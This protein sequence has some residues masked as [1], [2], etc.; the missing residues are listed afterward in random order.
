MDSPSRIHVSDGLGQAERA[1]AA[2]QDGYFN[3]NEMTLPALLSLAVK[4]AGLVAFVDPQRAG[5]S[6]EQ[7]FAAD[8]TVVISNMLN[9]ELRAPAERFNAWLDA[10]NQP[11][12]KKDELPTF[13]LVN[14]LDGWH[15]L[16]ARSAAN[17][18][19]AALRGLIASVM[20]RLKP[21]L[22]PL[23]RIAAEGEG[24]MTR[25]AAQA[26]RR[27]SAA[28]LA[29]P[30]AAQRPADREAERRMLR[31]S[32]YSLLKGVELVQRE[33]ARRLE[34]SLKSQRHDGA[35]ALLI[36]FCQL[37]LRLKFK[38]NRFT[39]QHLDFYHRRVLGLRPQ[40][41][42]PD[43]AYLVLSAAGA[44]IEVEIK[45]G[46][47][48]VAGRDAEQRDI[49]YT[50]DEDLSVADAR[51]AALRMLYFRR[52]PRISPENM[53]Y[54]DGPDEYT[55]GRAFPTGCWTDRVPLAPGAPPVIGHERLPHALFGT[56]KPNTV[57][58]YRAPARLGFAVASPM[59]LLA[60]GRRT[61]ELTLKFDD[62]L[63]WLEQ[64][65]RTIAAAMHGGD[66]G[67][68]EE[69]DAFFKIFRDI[70][71]VE[72]T[73]ETGWTTVEEYLPSYAGVDSARPANALALRMVL[74]PEFP[75][76]TA[77]DRAVH[78]EQYGTVSPV[79][80]FTLRD[81][82]Y[83]YPYALLKSL[84]VRE[85]RIAV[86]AEGCRK[87]IL[88]NGIG[89]LSPL[90]AFAPFGPQPAIGS[91]LVVG[92][93]E[94][95]RK[96]L[97]AF[98]VEIEW[99]GL[100]L[101]PGGFRAYYA[102]YDDPPATEE[103]RANLSTLVDGRWLPELE[104][105][106]ELQLYEVEADDSRRAAIAPRR[107]LSCKRVLHAYKPLRDSSV[108]DAFGPE[109]R[110][111][112]FRF[113]LS[114]PDFAFG[115][116]AYPNVLA[117][118]LAHNTRQKVE[119]RRRA[120]PNPPYTPMINAIGVSYRAESAFEVLRGGETVDEKL[121][122]LHPFGVE[123]LPSSTYG[124]IG[125]V[126]AY[127]EAG[128]LYIGV[129]ARKPSGRLTLMFH[130]H[131]DSEPLQPEVERSIRWHYL[132]DNQWKPLRADRIL[133]DS[134]EAFLVSGVVTLELPPDID[135]D[136]TVMPNG[137]HWLRISADG[138]DRAL[139]AFCSVHGVYINA[140]RVTW[141]Q[142]EEGGERADLTIPPGTITGPQDAIPGLASVTQVASSFGGRAAEGDA[143]LR[144]RA[145]E[146]LRHKQ[147]ALLPADYEQLVLEHFPE[148]YKVK[149]FPNLRQRIEHDRRI[150]PGG[151][152]IVPIAHARNEVEA[153][154]MPVLSGHLLGRIHRY[155][156][157][158]A[159]PD[160][161]IEVRNPWFERIQVR[162]TVELR[163]PYHTGRDLRA[164]NRALSDF[165]SPWGPGGN[166]THFGWAVHKQ[167]VEAFMLGL[168]YVQSVSGL[169]MLH[170]AA[171]N[172]AG[173]NYR[174]HDTVEETHGTEESLVIRAR[175]P[176]SVP[177]PVAQHF[178]R[179][180][181]GRQY[182]DRPERAGLDELA[183]DSTFIIGG[184]H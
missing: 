179:L 46:T 85:V 153:H 67:S 23:H 44:D 156:A 143:E 82:V 83:L 68:L 55:R 166:P 94:A 96:P 109:V 95:A 100:P 4:Y 103:I 139:Q 132:V 3:V 40:P 30:G 43:S 158:L 79:L 45:T 159:Q 133:S 62:Q 59:L 108:P 111:G 164:L 151:V 182:G 105:A 41:L 33:A 152:L 102:G 36:A 14:L 165:I 52:D 11:G 21:A 162:C 178:L 70:F 90:S 54:E 80:R 35:T 18:L 148:V 116:Q 167:D 6:W 75:A 9:I 61:I 104:E 176:W 121:I 8:E 113:T 163:D 99:A 112:M 84:A 47:A 138:D 88:H 91:Y 51:V 123:S 117:N 49:V 76:I 15:A 128:Y 81:N 130:L 147:R 31:W 131:Q 114:S 169:S 72:V 173:D 34:E 174:M 93:A 118:T 66:I 149:C 135:C 69:A 157:E 177:A 97:T 5:G 145:A 60:E 50:A 126:P 183:I 10:R 160:M 122:H 37:F 64:R 154:E 12:A 129:R 19:S 180:A 22:A 87:L 92:C 125:V 48:F 27:W 142:P 184:T 32:F 137:L 63:Q 115:H 38:L 57:S 26:L 150:R 124:R 7:Y 53:L 89:D 77:Y 17:P 29:A 146:R 20:E 110:N 39:G 175:Y 120:T 65:V 42:V 141:Q 144:T 172:V 2:L 1:L 78:R 101:A 106:P 74:Q 171:N 86:A 24:V 140:L 28:E 73:T 16:L 13:E 56:P 161:R 136:N 25:Q 155:L 98:D 119:S 71:N 58:Q 181:D 107:T 168:P 134:T 170:I 127:E